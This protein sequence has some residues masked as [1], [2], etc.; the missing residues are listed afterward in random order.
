LP[1]AK[2]ARLGKLLRAHLASRRH[3]IAIDDDRHGRPQTKLAPVMMAGASTIAQ[4]T[5][6]STPPTISAIA[7]S[8]MLIV[9]PVLVSS[10]LYRR[11]LEASDR[12]IS[13]TSR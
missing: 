10:P 8:L 12:I 5:P 6:S 11:Q 1:K 2:P 9:V 3:D 4:A 13:S 7:I